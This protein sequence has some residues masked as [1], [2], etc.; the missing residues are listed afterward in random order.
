MQEEASMDDILSSIRKI[1]S[2]GH[3]KEH[4]TVEPIK[5]AC[6]KPVLI[7]SEPISVSEPEK[8]VLTE[9]EAFLLTPAMRVNSENPETEQED[10][11][12]D[13]SVLTNAALEPADVVSID[14][15]LDMQERA[16]NPQ[17]LTEQVA[18]HL[19]EISVKEEIQPFI[20]KWLDEH[21]SDIVEKVVR[22][23]VGRVLARVLK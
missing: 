19:S 4:P 6:A 18:A 21:L 13:P 1:L 14:P 3:K 23:E 17:M 22:E 10:I 9:E 5:E 12:M 20:Q 16:L 11:A 7:E 15:V 8:E 2:G